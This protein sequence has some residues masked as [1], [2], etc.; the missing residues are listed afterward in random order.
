MMPL[1]ADVFQR[2]LAVVCLRPGPTVESYTVVP[3]YVRGGSRLT[4]G[5]RKLY[6]PTERIVN[7]QLFVSPDGRRIALI[8]RAGRA[9]RIE[10]L[11][12]RNL[13]P[14]RSLP[15]PDAA[16]IIWSPDSDHMAYQTIGRGDGRVVSSLKPQAETL[17]RFTA[18][19]WNRSGKSLYV[20]DSGIQPLI[21]P[22]SH[23]L[24]VD[25]W[26]GKQRDAIDHEVL[27]DSW[28]GKIGLP[29]V[30]TT[31]L[32]SD[33]STLWTTYG[34]L[35]PFAEYERGKPVQDQ[36]LRESGRKTIVRPNPENSFSS[37]LWSSRTLISYL[38]ESVLFDRGEAPKDGVWLG[39]FDLRTN[40]HSQYVLWLPA[41]LSGVP[42]RLARC[43]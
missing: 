35:W 15:A 26:S 41:Q 5:V 31:D 8:V 34:L 37:Q 13:S 1:I 38:Q 6:K 29:Q 42:L 39:S 18:L 9:T 30:R 2:D 20:S 40:R 33:P 43:G 12:T 32:S 7:D 16:T 22:R 17:P 19:V 21:R 25:V 3:D 24:R 11:R 28:I 10:V 4:S 14:I 23:W 27:V 36:V